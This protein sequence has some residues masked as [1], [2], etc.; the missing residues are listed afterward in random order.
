MTYDDHRPPYGERAVSW[1][2]IWNDAY[3]DQAFDPH[4][5]HAATEMH[6]L[7][8]LVMAQAAELEAALGEVIVGLN[9]SSDPRRRTAGRL[10]R[11]VR[12]ALPADL[13]ADW[14]EPLHF[15]SGAIN[16]RNHSV[17]Q[18][19][20]IGSVWRDY[21]TGDGGEWVPVVSTMGQEDYGEM[22]LLDDLT[23]QQ[24]AT[25]TAVDLLQTVRARATRQ[26]HR[27]A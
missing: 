22:E 23:L 14:E 11:E 6:R 5:D 16:R 3:P 4:D 19:V 18:T 25:V 7:R 12:E 27:S 9:P 21:A 24:R 15:I 2:T 26:P 13:A 17:H 10:L 20:R 8:G 1:L